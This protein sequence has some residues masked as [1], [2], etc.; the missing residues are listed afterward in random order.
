MLNPAPPLAPPP[1]RQANWKLDPPLRQQCRND[2]KQHCAEQDDRSEL[3][4]VYK[5]L[6][7][8]IGS[9][10]GGCR[11]ELG[12]AVHMAFFVWIPGGLLTKP[13]DVDIAEI[14][15]KDR[16]NMLHE[17]GTVS[18]CMANAV[19]APFGV[20]G[21]VGFWV[22]GV[23]LLEGS[24]NSSSQYPTLPSKQPSSTSSQY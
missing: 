9:L 2:V 3:G 18:E 23:G 24:P 8:N 5:C 13:C 10:A 22:A 7:A 14:C 1:P 15:L 20:F 17:T 19:R 11:A 4:L 21:E 16:P 12:R 6:L